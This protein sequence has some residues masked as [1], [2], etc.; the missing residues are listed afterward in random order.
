MNMTTALKKKI[1]EQLDD[2]PDNSIDDLLKYIQYLKFKNRQY[3]QNKDYILTN[4]ASEKTLSYDWLKPE[5]DEAW[6][7]L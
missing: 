6:K 4:L 2:V 5:E 3:P 7:D 1:I